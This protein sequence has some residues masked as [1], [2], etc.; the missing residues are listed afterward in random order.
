MERSLKDY[1]EDKKIYMVDPVMGVIPEGDDA[2]ESHFLRAEMKRMAT[3]V[4]GK[5]AQL[6]ILNLDS[7][8]IKDKI[9][10]SESGTK[11]SPLS[12]PDSLVLSPFSLSSLSP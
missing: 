3:S 7:D 2:N 12:I 9:H 4:G 11:R 1:T 5:F 8:D 10:L 6:D